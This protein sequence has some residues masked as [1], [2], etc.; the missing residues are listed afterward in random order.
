M[1]NMVTAIF[2]ARA[3]VAF[4]IPLRLATCI[5]RAF[6]RGKPIHR[7]A[8]EKTHHLPSKYSGHLSDNDKMPGHHDYAE[9]FQS[10]FG[11]MKWRA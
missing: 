4:F 9:V 3:R 5:A 1:A 11:K 6:I 8:Q 7:F 10:I 2:R